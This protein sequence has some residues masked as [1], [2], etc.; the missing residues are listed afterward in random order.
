MIR[1]YK[2]TDTYIYDCDLS[3]YSQYGSCIYAYE[4]STV[5]IGCSEINASGRYGFRG[6]IDS[7]NKLTVFLSDVEIETDEASVYDFGSGVWL[8]DCDL[9][10]PDGGRVNGGKIETSSGSRANK[11]SIKKWDKYDL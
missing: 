4:Y 9:V 11:V 7:G 5:K 1:C 3:L 2:D 8:E 10:I 6:R